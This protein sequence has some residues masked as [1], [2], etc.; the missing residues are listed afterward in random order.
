M[1]REM[2]YHE[3]FFLFADAESEWRNTKSKGIEGIEFYN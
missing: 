2:L 3:T 1:E